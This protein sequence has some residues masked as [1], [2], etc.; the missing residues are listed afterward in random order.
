MVKPTKAS[1]NLSFSDDEQPDKQYVE[2]LMT[3]FSEIR[4]KGSS[5]RSRNEKLEEAIKKYRSSKSG[6]SQQQRLAAVQKQ[7]DIVTDSI[8]KT[9][10]AI[11][12]A[13]RIKDEERMK[14]KQL[15]RGAL[16]NFLADQ[17]RRLPLYI[18]EAGTY[19]P[20][21]VGAIPA[22]SDTVIDAGDFVAAFS[23]EMGMWIL[24]VITGMQGSGSGVRFKC[25]DIEDESK[26]M[27]LT[28]R[29][30]VPL[31]QYRANPQADD[32]AVFPMDAVVMAMYP[33]TTCFYKAAVSAPPTTATD[34]YLIAFDDSTSL[35]GY[36]DP[37]SVPQRYVL[38]YRENPSKKSKS[39]RDSKRKA[40][41][42]ED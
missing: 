9:L 7:T 5:I 8:R 38:T 32:H 24:A 29:R 25:H 6:G 35:T 11:Y 19:P 27:I 1:L 10:D 34:D 31:P 17:A 20:P 42:D 3:C 4:S 12:K 22:Q 39:S 15:V 28:K 21:L 14:S 41:D 16:V 23:E 37:L 36:A 18:C 13:R 2:R 33:Q 26:V 30:I 40:P